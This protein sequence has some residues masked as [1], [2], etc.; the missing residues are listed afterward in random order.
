MERSERL[1]GYSELVSRMRSNHKH[2]E[3]L[4]QCAT[5]AVESCIKDGILTD[6][7]ES[8][9]MGVIGMIL[10]EYSFEEQVQRVHRNSYKEGV[11]DGHAEGFKKGRAEGGHEVRKQMLSNMFQNMGSTP[12]A[13]KQIAA[14]TGLSVAE[15]ESIKASL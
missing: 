1:A 3:D 8:N 2:I 12:D 10:E 14:L 4:T 7:L 9:K 13:I 6:F 5:L 15:V 11:E